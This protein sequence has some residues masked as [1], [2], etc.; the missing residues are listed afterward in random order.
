MF[1]FEYDVQNVRKQYGADISLF[2]EIRTDFVKVYSMLRRKSNES[3][4]N[5]R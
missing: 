1:F 2:Y 4:C 3:R 5:V